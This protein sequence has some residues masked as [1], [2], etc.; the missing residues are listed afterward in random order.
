MIFHLVF[1]DVADGGIGVALDVVATATRLLRAG[2]CSAPGAGQ[3]LTQRIVSTDGQSV[4]TFAE[5][6]LSVDGSLPV[7]QV[8]PGDV[9][10]LAGLSAATPAQIAAL[11]RRADVQRGSELLAQAVAQGALVA[12]SCSATFV[13]AASGVLHGRQ[14]TTTWWL[15]R[16]FSERYP[17]IDL[18]ID[19]MVVDSQVAITAGAALSHTDLML[20]IVSRMVS[21]S[22]SQLIASYL[23]LEQR[24]SQARYMI[25]ESLRTQDP[26]IQTLERFLL[27]NLSRQISTSEMARATATSP[28]TLS[29]RL[30]ELLA[31]SPQ[32]FVQR[33]RVNH[34]VYLLQTTQTPVE[35]IAAGVGYA[36]AAAFRRIFQRETGQ[37]PREARARIPQRA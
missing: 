20:A 36:D 31:M 10:V 3:A 25:Q 29:R 32:R 17:Q 15:A 33:L 30:A 14:A 12:A 9:I 27:A 34:A 1:D 2:V 13:L 16:Q 5:R 4:R 37:T 22:L 35:E 28:R 19:R 8:G 7:E 18:R 21:P 6:T 24:E 23:V 11:L 26:L